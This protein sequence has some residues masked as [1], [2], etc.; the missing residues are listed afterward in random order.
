MVPLRSWK[1]REV[2][3][4][5]TPQMNF[6][7]FFHGKMWEKHGKNHE[8]HGKYENNGKYGI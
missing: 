1:A 2:R 8:N 6:G 5:G 3:S 4:Y 7:H